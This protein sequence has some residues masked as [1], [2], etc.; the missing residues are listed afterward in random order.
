MMRQTLQLGHGATL[1][2]T[3][4]VAA[5]SGQSASTFAIPKMD[6]LSQLA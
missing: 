1:K 6:R 2:Y 5:P 4:P 3:Q